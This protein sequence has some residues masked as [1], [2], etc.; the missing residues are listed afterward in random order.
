MAPGLLVTELGMDGLWRDLRYGARRLAKA[1]ALAIVASL[2]LGLAVAANGMIFSLLDAL[3]FRPPA[4]E[5]PESLARLYTGV[6]E[7]PRDRTSFPDF[8]VYRAELSAF[9][10][11]VASGRRGPL[12]RV[13]EEAEMVLAEVVS[14]NYFDALGIQPLLG[15]A[16]RPDVREPTDETR[17]LISH[18]LWQRRFGADPGIVGEPISLT[19]RNLVVG[20]VLPRAFRGLDRLLAVD[21]WISLDTWS[22]QMG[23]AAELAQRGN[24]W[25]DIWGRLA[26]EATAEQAAA[27]CAVVADRLAQAHPET[28][29]ERGCAIALEMEQRRRQGVP[30]SALLFSL[31]GLVLLVCCANIANLLLAQAEARRREMAT[32]SALGASRFRIAR[33]VAA[34][35]LLLAGIGTLL[36]LTI[37]AWLL[38]LLPALMPQTSL[39]LS[40]DFAVDARVAG[41][42]AAAALVATVL[43]GAAPA[44]RASRQ[45]SMA[46]LRASRSAEGG[47]R[48]WLTARNALV[49]AQVS[50]CVVLLTASGLL[51]RSLAAAARIDPGF[52]R[53]PM[54]V[55]SINPGLSGYSRE[56]SL[57]LLERLKERLEALPGIERASYAQR[58]PLSPTGGGAQVKV[59]A[60]ATGAAPQD[61]KYNA[62][63]PGY[64]AT[65]G[66]RVLRG[67]A[68]EDLDRK[69]SR[70]VVVISR[71]MA[72]RFWGDTDPVG[73]VLRTS[74][75]EWQIVGV[76]EDVTINW[77]REPPEP[78]LYFPFAQRPRSEVA[79]LAE[80]RGRAGPPEQAAAFRDVLRDT[81]SGVPVLDLTTQ[82][83]LVRLSL[84]NELVYARLASALGAIGLLLAATGLFGV[85][86]YLVR[87]R[88]KEIGVRLA[89]G[90]EPVRILTSFVRTGLAL[91][92]AGVAVGSS[93]SLVLADLLS[94]LLYGVSPRDPLSF[95][96]AAGLM[97]L[98]T[99][100]AALLPS[101][102][103]LRVDPM[104]ALRHD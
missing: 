57:A 73:D 90:A 65:M 81:A 103:A 78:Y 15:G 60:P 35:S 102:A 79:V 40:L 52:E 48:S 63:E 84:Y 16:W 37:A 72:E 17:V 21:V 69:G 13:D 93:A 86:S 82:D 80:T 94:E 39:R 24:R 83:S 54:L 104:Q 88:T 22:S 14:R 66:T 33:Q 25:L 31:A 76:A 95:L 4:V 47:G 23:S 19:G 92:A 70:P 6:P 41:F 46:A 101:R 20:G 8:E 67:R 61:V 43:F 2:T 77:L 3:F 50:A 85:I 62:V 42:T 53:K 98:V 7:S 29:A 32:R 59:E 49:A 9:S 11:L 91:G 99:A 71:T 34:E 1:P 75:T 30:V 100:V 10:T 68:F 45:G 64:F 58:A 74:G 12:L 36:G 26:P 87:T 97:L 27:E 96:G 89:L 28:N 38:E 55:A 56:E 51:I 5:R 18:D 44:L